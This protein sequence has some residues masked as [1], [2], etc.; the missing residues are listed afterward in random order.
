M[1]L[2]DPFSLFFSVKIHTN[3][4]KKD[5]FVARFLLFGKNFVRLK[6]I[7]EDLAKNLQVSIGTQ[8]IEGFLNVNTFLL[9]F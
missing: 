1:P 2:L 9:R 5:S 6:I 4:R 3:T 8:K 7:K